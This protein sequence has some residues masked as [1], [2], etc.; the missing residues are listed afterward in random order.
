MLRHGVLVAGSAALLAFAVF[1][2]AQQPAGKGG[3]GFG[4]GGVANVDPI[5]LLRRADV[6]KELDLSEQQLDKLPGAVMKA[7]AEVL[8]DKQMK[9]FRQLELQ[10]KDT[11]AFREAA[12]RKELKIT[13]SQAKDIDLVMEDTRK[14][15]ADIFAD[16][17][18]SGNFKGLFEKVKGIQ[19]E[20]K[21]K[22][23]R[24]LTSDQKQTWKAM[25]GE[26]FTY[27]QPKVGG[28]G[29]KEKADK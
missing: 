16:V 6:K 5:Q 7:I 19:K 13:E 12:I 3:F 8:N 26:E 27:E 1:S 20:T 24:I 23:I 18:A 2:E 9:R 14:E 17:K 25:L 10:K 28:F 15:T 4:F 22:L 11:A 21:E 29:N